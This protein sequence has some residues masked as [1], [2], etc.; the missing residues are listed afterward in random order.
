[1]GWVARATSRAVT[2]GEKQVM[3]ETLTAD[4]LRE[5]LH[6]DPETGNFTWR[7]RV[8]R[9]VHVGDVAGSV[10]RDRL[11]G[12]HIAHAYRR[13]TI[14]GGRHGRRYPAHRLAWLYMTGEWPGGDLDHIDRN[15][16]NNRWANLRL[17]TNSQNQANTVAWATGTSGFKGVNWK[18]GA[19]WARISVRRRRAFLGCFDTPGSAALA[20]AIAAEKHFGEF[21]RPTLEDTCLSIFMDAWRSARWKF[22]WAPVARHE[23]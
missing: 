3:T 10:C 6:Y 15:P 2:D 14:G 21:G 17:A 20:Y 13:N 16:T 5:L 9:R 12:G 1:M 22:D 19:W 18:N 23:Q 8:A 4:R 11:R 7:V